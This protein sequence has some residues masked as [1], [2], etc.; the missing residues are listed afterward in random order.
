MKEDSGQNAPQRSPGSV[1]NDQGLGIDDL[2]R[3]L[4]RMQMPLLHSGRLGEIRERMRRMLG[5]WAAGVLQ[6]ATDVHECA[7]RHT[8][9]WLSALHHRVKSPQPQRLA[10]D[11]SRQAGAV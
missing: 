5:A 9:R 11:D 7:V 1:S 2:D 6:M 10:A 3:I 8:E 4:G